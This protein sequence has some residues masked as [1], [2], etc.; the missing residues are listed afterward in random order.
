M[1]SDAAQGKRIADWQAAERA[2][3]R[4]GDPGGLYEAAGKLWKSLT[5]VDA[6]VARKGTGG[7]W[8]PVEMEQMKTGTQDQHIRAQEQNTSALNAMQE[9]ASGSKEVRLFDR[10]SKNTLGKELTSQFDLSALRNVNTA[11]R[12]LQ[13]KGF[14]RDIP[15]LREILEEVATGLVEHGLPPTPPTV[16]PLTGGQRRD[17]KAAR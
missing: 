8:R 13:G 11:T 14:D 9:I 7:K 12:G 2:A 16:P 5:E 17:N 4:R 3:G 15:F 1:G 6:L 10:T